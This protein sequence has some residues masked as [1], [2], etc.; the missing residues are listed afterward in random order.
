M[1]IQKHFLQSRTYTKH[2]GEFCRSPNNLLTASQKRKERKRLFWYS[3]Y[4]W[5]LPLLMVLFTL[6]AKEYDFLPL[7]FRPLLGEFKCLLY[8]CKYKIWK[9]QKNLTIQCSS[10]WKLLQIGLLRGAH[11]NFKNHGSRT[12]SEDNTALLEN[13][14]RD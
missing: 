5:G 2:F 9:P 11:N 3:T 13:K 10:L 1:T 8:S 7:Q 4:G 6:L 12:V 14:E